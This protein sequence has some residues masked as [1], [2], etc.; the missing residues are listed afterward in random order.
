MLTSLPVSNCFHFLAPTTLE[1]WRG[2]DVAGVVGIL[3]RQDNGELVVID[4]FDCD[5]VPDIKE[6]TLDERFGT[7]VDM[8]GGP[9]RIRF[10]VFLMPKA[11]A[12]RRNQVVMLLER[13]CGFK[14]LQLQAYAHAV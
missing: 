14:A 13:S 3:S 7:W 9:E 11:E 1:H 2:Y 5:Q 6:L 8:A 10:D 12:I 4:A